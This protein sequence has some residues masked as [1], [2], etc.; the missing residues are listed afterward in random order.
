MRV[1]I[2]RSGSYAI[3]SSKSNI[4]LTNF[5]RIDISEHNSNKVKGFRLSVNRKSI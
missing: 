5:C 2:E 1:V 4:Y 3:Y